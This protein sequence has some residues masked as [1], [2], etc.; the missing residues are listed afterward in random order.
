MNL[1]LPPPRLSDH[2]RKL[3][4]LPWPKP[5]LIF[6]SRYIPYCIELYQWKKR[7][8]Q[9]LAWRRGNFWKK[10]FQKD[11]GTRFLQRNLSKIMPSDNAIKLHFF[12]LKQNNLFYT[13]FLLCME[14]LQKIKRKMDHR[15]IG[16]SCNTNTSPFYFW[17]VKVAIH[18]PA[19]FI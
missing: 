2:L 10:K 12:P 1:Q 4:N 13:S 15:L 18:K 3:S 14:S 5:S 19:H 11:I 9:N 17:L 7:K 16:K 6:F 8:Q